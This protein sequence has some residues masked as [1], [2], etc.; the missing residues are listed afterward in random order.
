MTGSMLPD[1]SPTQSP[2]ISEVTLGSTLDGF[3]VAPERGG[4]VT[5]Y[6][7]AGVPVLY[8]DR[9]TLGGRG[10]VRGGIPVLFPACG[11]L[12]D[13]RTTLRAHEVALPQHGF[14][15]NLPW[16]VFSRTASEITLM[17]CRDDATQAMYPFDFVVRCTYALRVDAPDLAVPSTALRITVSVEN[18]STEPMPYSLGFHPYFAIADKRA[19]RFEL[20]ATLAAE[21]PYGESRAFD[22]FDFDADSVD[23]TFT[24]MREPRAAFE[25]AGWRTEIEC[26]EQ[27]RYFVFWTLRD[28]SFVCLEGWTAR[29][30]ALNSQRDLLCVPPGTSQDLWMEIRRTTLSS[31]SSCT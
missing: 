28:R 8:L 21:N 6:T 18:H 16:E 11:P 15:R 20:P 9:P 10:S 30:D 1:G 27:F 24:D 29:A 14:A 4:M 23:L 12:R 5:A 13:G 7:V 26:S 19:A 17:L 2:D 25:A 3:T 22:G 31:P